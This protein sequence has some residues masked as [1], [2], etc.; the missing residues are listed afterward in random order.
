MPVKWR[1]IT[2]D[3]TMYELYRE[4]RKVISRAFYCIRQEIDQVL[5]KAAEECLKFLFG[6]Y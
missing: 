1:L 4:A 2:Q 3:T 6:P 5:E